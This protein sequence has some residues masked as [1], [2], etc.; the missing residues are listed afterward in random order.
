MPDGKTTT[1]SSNNLVQNGS[2]E[3]GAN[4]GA[5]LPLQ[6]GSTAIT[7]WTVILGG[8][9][10]V[11]TDWVSSNRNRSLDLNGSPG[12]GGLSKLLPQRPGKHIK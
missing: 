6:P 4:P 8:I 7:N 9:D 2:F 1:P 5:N 3:Q 12:V 10:Y 11:G